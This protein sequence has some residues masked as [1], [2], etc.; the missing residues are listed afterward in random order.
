MHITSYRT[1]DTIILALQCF[2]VPSWRRERTTPVRGEYCLGA[3][4]GNSTNYLFRKSLSKNGHS[5]LNSG[6][7]LLHSN[8]V[9]VKFVML[10]FNCLDFTTYNF[11]LKFCSSNWPFDNN[12][13]ILPIGYRYRS[14]L[15]QFNKKIGQLSS[16]R[17]IE[18]TDRI[19]LT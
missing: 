17:D 6:V 10:V 11:L 7:I 9:A 1:L 15:G 13:Q 3:C 19:F 2:D 14:G 16:S 4:A 8:Q 18:N 12:A 5:L